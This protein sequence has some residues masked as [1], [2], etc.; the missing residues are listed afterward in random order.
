MKIEGYKPSVDMGV[1]SGRVSV[2]QNALA[3]GVGGAGLD[4]I[5]KGIGV[6]A[7]VVQKQ[8]DDEDRQVILDAMD[9]YNKGRYNI[10]YNDQTGLMHTKLDGSVGIADSFTEQ[11]QK[12]RAD[13]LGNLKL[14]N[15]DNAVALNGMMNKSAFQGW[16]QVHQ[17]QLKQADALV[18]VRYKN[19]VENMVELAQKDW[20]KPEVLDS[21]LDDTYL[22]ANAA[23]G[24]KSDSKVLIDEKAK[25]A[26]GDIASAAIT[27]AITTGDYKAAKAYQDKYGHYLSAAQRAAFDKVVLTKEIDEYSY[28]TAASL[29]DLYGDDEAAVMAALDKTY[30][31]DG[32]T[33]GSV[34]TK[35][36]FIAAIAGQESG[37]NYNA[38]NARTGASGK[39]QIMPENWG[40]WAREAGLPEGAEMMPENQE[41]VARFKLGQYYDKYGARGAAIAWYAGE[42]ALSYS[43]GALNRKQGN[44]DE[45]SINEYADSVLGR[46]G[47][48]NR[49]ERRLLNHQEKMEMLADYQRIREDKKRIE[50]AE[51][52]RLFDVVSS[53]IIKMKDGGTSYVD[54]M[55]W[56]EQ[57]AG[58]DYKKLKNYKSAVKAIY[59]GYGKDGS[60]SPSGE[61]IKKA[62]CNKLYDMLK[63]GHFANKG[64]FLEYARLEGANDA[65]MD[66]L[67]KG[68]ENYL[69]GKGYFKF[70]FENMVTEITGDVRLSKAKKE[71]LKAGLKD[72]MVLFVRDYRHKHNGSD[73]SE[74]EVLKAGAEALK[75]KSYGR[76][77][78]SES[79]LWDDEKPVN[80][81]GAQLARAGIA[82]VKPVEWSNDMFIVEYSDGRA[83]SIISNKYLDELAGGY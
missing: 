71:T 32:N 55:K 22:L 43:Q 19:N 4:A 53:D 13:I 66:R 67:N 18:D 81:S 83:T 37:G 80:L 17:Y 72:A 2:P 35:E 75:T 7:N 62:G 74:N 27:Q 63:A 52:D 34:P 69:K 28:N 51:Y 26:M 36:A 24:L 79:W 78:V 41:K 56:A 21:L 59:G 14:H 5:N 60:G 47:T 48:V 10:M 68:Y 49:G 16:E 30:A 54:A 45:P 29:Y 38:V 70:D 6:V 39:Y 25:A 58:S 15:K 65:D 64:E 8:Q 61:G 3:Y 50:R 42:G 82:S 23:Y 57:Q 40:P 33:E 12:L 46:M 31:F 76:Y 77:V 9:L 1:S 44:G 11:E 20:N 73:P